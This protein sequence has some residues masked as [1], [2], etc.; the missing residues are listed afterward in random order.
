ML[1]VR[2]LSKRFTVHALDGK[3]IEGFKDV[4]FDLAPGGAAALVGPSGA[5]K[6]SVLKCLYRTYLPT[7]GS[8]VY[9]SDALGG[10]DLAAAPEQDILA[11]RRSEI[12]M[13]SQFLSVIP[14][15]SAVDVVAEAAV[16]RLGSWE[17][18][19]REAGSLLDRLRI[20]S[21]LFDAFP[22][23]FSGGEQ[24]R[25]NIA[26]A[27]IGRPSLLLLDEPTASLDPRS[28]DIVIE[29]LTE[30]RAGIADH[31]P[32]GLVVILHDPEVVRRLT[33]QV[34]ALKPVAEPGPDKSGVRGPTSPHRREEVS[35]VVH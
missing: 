2:N 4:S 23:T 27:V 30:L 3:A 17:A 24:Q 32:V 34:V 22:A 6:S 1:S 12:G 31:R 16:E 21:T 25:V 9:H 19:R 28:A 8:A 11:L 13:V 18:A 29:I 15:V 33:D 35:H 26:R 20:P 7:G 5:G 14:R 10:V